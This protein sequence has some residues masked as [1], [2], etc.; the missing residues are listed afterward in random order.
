MSA[1]WKEL[2]A[3]KKAEQQASIPS[4]WLLSADKLPPAE[5]KDVTGVPESC[6]LLSAREVEITNTDVGPLLKKMAAAEWSAS[7]VTLAFCKRAIV[8]QQLTNCLTEIFIDRAVARAKELD[9]Y[10]AK[11]GQVVGPLHGLPISLKDQFSIKGLDTVMGYTT[12]IG[13]PAEKN[14][15]LVDV[16]LAA[17]AVLYVRTNVPQTLM[18]PETF[19]YIYGRTTN[20]H[21]RDLASGG[22]SGGEGSLVALK[23]SPLGV[24]TDIGGSIRIPSACCGLYG[25]RPSFHRVT[26][27]GAKNSML[28]QDTIPSVAGP[29]CN[30]LEGVTVFMRAVLGQ[31]PWLQDPLAMRKSWDE[32][33]YQLVEHGGGKKL[34]FGFMWDDG[35]YK[36][37]PPI[38]RAMKLVKEALIAAGHSV[39]DWEPLHH[40]ELVDLAS[41]IWGSDNGQDFRASL[42]ATGEPLIKT[43]IPEGVEIVAHDVPPIIQSKDTD[44]YGL[45][46]LHKRKTE[47]REFYLDHWNASVAKTGTGRPV[48]ALISPAAPY[49]A[50]PH[51]MYRLASY[52]TVFNV[53]D[54]PTCVVPVT[55]VHPALDA[56]IP[57]HEFRNIEDKIVYEMYSPEVFANAPLCV[58]VVGRT[59]EDEAV[60]GI[61]EIVDA[62]VKAYS[63]N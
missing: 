13:K 41:N 22:S 6:G 58:Q 42:A 5:Q 47:L 52:T 28:G 40:K 34:C 44:A 60:L 3:A 4:A 15:T 19:N 54:Y 46:Q 17:G 63:K 59:Q 11:T 9:E 50:P 31:K 49:P 1:T 38:T 24:G 29:L 48:D 39:I 8:A 57:A 33:A 26:Y 37:L 14:C 27:R 18:W 21:N 2:A 7:D 20:P 43:M 51:G 23:G 12:G 10:L 62:A 56:K 36:P 45:W 53:L 25:L 30:S 55:R 35:D 16:L 32:E 61:S